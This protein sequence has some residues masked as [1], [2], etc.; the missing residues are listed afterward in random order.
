V[1]KLTKLVLTLQP[2]IGFAKLGG[3]TNKACSFHLVCKRFSR[4]FEKVKLIFSLLGTSPLELK[5]FCFADKFNKNLRYLKL[6]FIFIILPE[7]DKN[8]NHFTIIV[9]VNYYQILGIFNLYIS[10]LFL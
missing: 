5:S 6:D 8:I 7:I 1:N 3:F 4:S 10:V 2:I 9:K